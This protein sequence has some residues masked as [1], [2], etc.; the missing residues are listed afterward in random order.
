MS[1]NTTG[2]KKRILVLGGGFGGVTTAQRLRK[3][4]KNSQQVEI[5]LV[6]RENFMVFVPM[7]ASA[8]AGSIDTLHVVNP[9]RRMIP[10]LRFRQEEVL[11]IDLR[12][13]QVVTT[14]PITGREFLLPYDHLVLGV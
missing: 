14:S 10:G 8:A 13:R 2:D 5:T 1:V 11:G 6:N 4:F 9:I 3:H 7:L 12:N